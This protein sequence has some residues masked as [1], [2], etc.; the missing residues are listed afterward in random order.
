MKKNININEK[1]K[2][3]KAKIM[4]NSSDAHFADV[5]IKE[6]VT[7]YNQKNTT[8]LALDCG[9]PIDGRSFSGNTFEIVQT[10][11]GMLYHC[12]GGYNIFVEPQNESL[13]QILTELIDTQNDVESWEGIEKENYIAFVQALT[14]VLNCPFYA[15][16]ND[17]LL[18][19]VAKCIIDG[20]TK[21]VEEAQEKELQ[22]ETIEEDRSFKEAVIGME[23]LKESVKE[24]A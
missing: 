10:E 2:E 18:F 3:V 8:T 12:F 6:L 9:T 20:L 5:L 1:I 19:D 24:Q 11:K 4:S 23:N 7:L 16:G 17:K 13:Y 15:V 21:L 22:D 14:Y